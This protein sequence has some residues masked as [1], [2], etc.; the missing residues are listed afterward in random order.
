MSE[1]YFEGKAVLNLTA[2]EMLCY[3]THRCGIFRAS[4]HSV[5]NCFIEVKHQCQ[6]AL[7]DGLRR[8]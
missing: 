6:L 7:L 2:F 4:G 5:Q 1:S 8:G 3:S